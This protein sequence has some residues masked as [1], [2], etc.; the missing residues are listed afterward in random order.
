ME[1]TSIKITTDDLRVLFEACNRYSEAA[2]G[3]QDLKIKL[4]AV[5][6]NSFVL[7]HLLKLGKTPYAFRVMLLPSEALMLC[8]VLSFFN[9]HAQD[10]GR[11]V[12][13]RVLLQIHPICQSM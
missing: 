4:V 6:A 7:K 3:N 8:I 11:S 1:K 9:D 10:Y 13:N 12:I 5:Q 2:Q